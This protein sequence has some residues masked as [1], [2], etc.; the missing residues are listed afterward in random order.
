[1]LWELRSIGRMYIKIILVGG[2]ISKTKKKGREYTGSRY[3]VFSM[4][5]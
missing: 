4:D 3:A 2:G 5:E 1:M